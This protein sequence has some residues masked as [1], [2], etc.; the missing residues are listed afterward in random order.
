MNEALAI[1]PKQDRSR[2]SAERMLAAA[3]KL[4]RERPFEEITIA[5]IVRE[6]SASIGSFYHRFA[7]KEA[8]LPA[9]YER[10]DTR[11]A[12]ELAHPPALAGSAEGG[13][14]LR[15]LIGALASRFRQEKWLLRAMAL[16]SR[17]SPE[18]VPESAVARSRSLYA[19]I[20]GL[21]DASPGGEAHEAERRLRFMTFALVTLLRE[22]C[23]F[24]EAPLSRALGLSRED[25]EQELAF[26]ALAYLGGAAAPAANDGE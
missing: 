24:E 8:L 11:S 12:Q 6:G 10:Y 13:G 22:R 25:F 20:S 14:R 7:S 19:T 15:L 2:R 23:L 18:A 1:P 26:M 3:E 4:L 21:L 5:D 9:L 16:F 17:A